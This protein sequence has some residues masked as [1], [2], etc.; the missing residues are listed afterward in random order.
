MSDGSSGVFGGL[1][2]VAA[3]RDV[4]V[5]T[6]MVYDGGKPDMDVRGKPLA[7]AY[8]PQQLHGGRKNKGAVF[9]LA[10]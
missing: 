4:T 9:N 3:L 2:G 7:G 10:S 1:G 8:L 6:I 5:D